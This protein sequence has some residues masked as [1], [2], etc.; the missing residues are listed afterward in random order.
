MPQRRILFLS[1]LFIVL[2]VSL[3]VVLNP[4]QHPLRRDN[5]P[6]GAYVSPWM[7]P[8]S[9]LN[10]LA[11]MA[12]SSLPW[13]IGFVMQGSLRIDATFNVPLTNGTRSIPATIY[14]GHDPSTLY[15]AGVLHCIYGNPT[16][17]ASVF[18]TDYFR[19]YF[20]SDNDGIVT[21]PE[22]GSMDSFT[23][24]CP[25]LP[26]HCNSTSW[27]Y[28][29]T[30]FYHDETWFD[31]ALGSGN[32]GWGF[33]Q[34]Y[35]QQPT[36]LVAWASEYFIPNGTW[37]FAFSRLLNVPDSCLNSLQMRA[38]ERWAIGFIMEVG[39]SNG[40]PIGGQSPYQDFVGGWPRNT[41]P[42]LNQ[43]ASW[44]PKLVID[45]ANPPTKY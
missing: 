2:T 42:D 16:S 5:V 28:P 39:Y 31:N 24:P 35:C 3:I 34:D 10:A 26:T 43:D 44:W 30:A 20:D 9:S 23:E 36:S 22:S 8:K 21:Q 12:Q 25:F 14:F 13:N 41:Y 15:V 38:G 11:S 37:T 17:S 29:F 33:P 40:S 4:F 18:Y 7:Q 6:S 19:V 32:P 1:L 27:I 45:L